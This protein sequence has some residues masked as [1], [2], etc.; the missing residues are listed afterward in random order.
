MRNNICYRADL[1]HNLMASN[2]KALE[3]AKRIL[4]KEP[5]VVFG[6]PFAKEVRRDPDCDFDFKIKTGLFESV[7]LALGYERAYFY[8][9]NGLKYPAH[10]NRNRDALWQIPGCDLACELRKAQQT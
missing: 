9:N 7:M 4:A 1:S 10:R 6:V 2:P 5:A 3:I 8:D